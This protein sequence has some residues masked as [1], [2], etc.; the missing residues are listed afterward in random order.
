[1]VTESIASPVTNPLL[2]KAVDPAPPERVTPC[3][4]ET[5]FAVTVKDLVFTV[6]FALV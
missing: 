1:M 5:L 2:V 3:T 6:R 4:L